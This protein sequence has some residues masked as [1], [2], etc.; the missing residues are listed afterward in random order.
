MKWSEEKPGEWFTLYI[1]RHDTRYAIVL[2]PNMRKSIERFKVARLHFNGVVVPEDAKVHVIC[3][4]LIFLSMNIGMLE[5][6]QIGSQ[7]HLGFLDVSEVDVKDVHK[8][9]EPDFVGPFEV[10]REMGENNV[11]LEQI[12]K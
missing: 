1:L 10:S 12:F 2:F 6:V 11:Y 8:S 4:P 3:K 5:K 7:L 9:P